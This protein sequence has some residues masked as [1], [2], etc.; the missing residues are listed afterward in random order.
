MERVNV[1]STNIEF[2]EYDSDNSLLKVGFTNGRSYE[3]KDVPQDIFN[4]F[5][6]AD[7]KGKFFAKHIKNKFK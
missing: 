5:K 2:I 4:N 3:Y 6:D 7:S 1:V